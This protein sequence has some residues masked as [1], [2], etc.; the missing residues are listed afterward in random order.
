MGGSQPAARVGGSE[1]FLK[2]EGEENP[3]SQFGNSVC[4]TSLDILL[5]AYHMPQAQ[6]FKG[7]PSQEP[8]SQHVPTLAYCGVVIVRGGCPTQIVANTSSLKMFCSGFA[9]TVSCPS[10]LMFALSGR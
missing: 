8:Q 2:V 5:S 1:A 10:F 9:T 4:S 7:A 3:G 6:K